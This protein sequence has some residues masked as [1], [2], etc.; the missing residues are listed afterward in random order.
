MLLDEFKAPLVQSLRDDRKSLLPAEVVELVFT[1]LA[2]IYALNTELSSHFNQKELVRNIAHHTVPVHAL[3][4]CDKERQSWEWFLSL[5]L[6]FA[7]QKRAGHQT[8][9]NLVTWF[10]TGCGVC[11]NWSIPEAILDLC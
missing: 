3:S 8:R 6:V 7:L 5:L 11:K 1:S 9:T 4:R 10:P 2:E